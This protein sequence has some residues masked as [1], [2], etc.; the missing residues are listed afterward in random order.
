MKK[1]MNTR[2]VLSRRKFKRLERRV[3]RKIGAEWNR[4]MLQ[5]GS[6]WS[7]GSDYS[8]LVL[9][10]ATSVTALPV[11]KRYR[12]SIRDR[13]SWEQLFQALASPVKPRPSGR[14]VVSCLFHEEKS[15]S[16]VTWADG[17][18]YCHGCGEG[19]DIV[20]FAATYKG[21]QTARDIKAFFSL[22]PLPP[23]E[24]I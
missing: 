21:L 10:W 7:G 18:F 3:E 14:Y 11:N 23:L 5:F 13:V 2:G 12:Q 16:L 4:P 6:R 1:Y 24:Q 8:R 9:D 15:P 19:G 22:L 17:G 20:L